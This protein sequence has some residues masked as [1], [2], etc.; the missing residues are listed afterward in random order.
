MIRVLA[1]ANFSAK[2]QNFLDNNFF[3]ILFGAINDFIFSLERDKSKKIRNFAIKIPSYY[4]TIYIRTTE[5]HA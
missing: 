2:I 1:N 3:Y 4:A 5:T